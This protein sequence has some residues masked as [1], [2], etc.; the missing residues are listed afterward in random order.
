MAQQ[1]ALLAGHQERI[2]DQYLEAVRAYFVEAAQR[3]RDVVGV[4]VIELDVVEA[5]AGGALQLLTQVAP[6]ACAIGIGRRLTVSVVNIVGRQI[7]RVIATVAL[8]ALVDLFAADRGRRRPR[9]VVAELDN[10]AR[11]GRGI[12]LE[13]DQVAQWLGGKLAHRPKTWPR[14]RN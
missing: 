9:G 12:A 6:E 5:L 10:I 13:P 4:E 11:V 2:F 7:G 1:I 8:I 3:R 14:R